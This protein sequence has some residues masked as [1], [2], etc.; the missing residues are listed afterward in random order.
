M[1][2]CINKYMIYIDIQYLCWQLEGIPRVFWWSF[3]LPHLAFT[4]LSGGWEGKAD[5]KMSFLN[6]GA[7]EVGEHLFK[8]ATNGSYAQLLS[9]SKN[10]KEWLDS[11]FKV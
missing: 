2:D 5:F 9:S 8:L 7:I 4:S 3:Y 1:L 10:Q 11:T 6:G